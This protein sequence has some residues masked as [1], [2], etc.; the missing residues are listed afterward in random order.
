MARQATVN[1]F[2]SAQRTVLWN[3]N[4]RRLGRQETT[5]WNYK[6]VGR[7]VF[8]YEI[9]VSSSYKL[10]S[11]F[12]WARAI[13]VPLPNAGSEEIFAEPVNSNRTENVNILD[14]RFEKSFR[15]S[16]RAGR[17]TGMVDIFN[18]TNAN[19]ITNFRI[20]TG[21]RFKEVISLLDP[22]IVRFGVR[23]DF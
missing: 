11:G 2:T 10:Q 15:F 8:P 1:P 4:R 21:P 14:F 5:Y 12:N 22:R 19:P 9:A 23:Y 17:L 13:S 20:V 3:Q 18:I 7:Y 16:S 6:L